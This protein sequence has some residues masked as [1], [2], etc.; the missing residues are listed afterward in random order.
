MVSGHVLTSINLG[1]RCD[2]YSLSSPNVLVQN[3]YNTLNSRRSSH[4]GSPQLGYVVP[5]RYDPWYRADNVQRRR[6][7]V[8]MQTIVSS[9]GVQSGRAEFWQTPEP[10]SCY[11]HTRIAVTSVDL[12]RPH[13]LQSS[14]VIMESSMHNNSISLCIS[15]LPKISIKPAPGKRS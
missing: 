12:Q 7:G 4:P 5:I 10:Q 11:S 1:A 6:R 14:V 8:A 3:D 13:I 15:R 9:D 2:M